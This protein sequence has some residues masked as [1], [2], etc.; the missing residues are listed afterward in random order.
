MNDQ[1]TYDAAPYVLGALSDGDRVAFE[2]HLAECPACAAE[3]SEF[4]EL[5]GLLAQLPPDDPALMLTDEQIEP[6][7]TLLPSL[8]FSVRRERRQRRWRVAV[9]T[10]LAAACVAG[11]GTAVILEQRVT[12]PAPAPAAV[13][14][15]FRPVRDIPVRAS[16]TLLPKPWGTEVR[17]A[18][19]YS[20]GGWAGDSKPHTYKL[21]AFDKA[22]DTHEAISSWSVLPGQEVHM[23]GSTAI[24]RDRLGKLEI[25]TATNKTVLELSL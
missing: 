18:C 25:Q 22:G 10:G 11:L 23:T 20:G 17:I 21:V 14:L 19:T 12:R 13:A 8:L 1:Y 5:P 16:A 7:A 15:Q 2:A 3:V 6:P 9:A 4:S 24:S